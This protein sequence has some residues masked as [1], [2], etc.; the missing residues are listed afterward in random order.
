M[1]T[2][3][4]PPESGRIALVGALLA[5]MALSMRLPQLAFAC[6]FAGL[7][8]LLTEELSDESMLTRILWP[9]RRACGCRRF[10]GPE[11]FE[12]TP[13]EVPEKVMAAEKQQSAPEEVLAPE[14]PA[15]RD[16]ADDEA[17][18]QGLF[19]GDHS[20]GPNYARFAVQRPRSA[21]NPAE[22]TRG[23]NRLQ[24]VAPTSF[25]HGNYRSST[26]QTSRFNIS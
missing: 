16:L 4:N 10:A 3:M 13:P 19:Y 18:G 22:A 2:K 20:G 5:V 14:E 15:R 26:G 8:S 9:K 24:R 6:A 21:S 1:W 17:Y 25:T 11:M 7:L 12:A 23:R